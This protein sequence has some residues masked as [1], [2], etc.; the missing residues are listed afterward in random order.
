MEAFLGSTCGF[1]LTGAKVIG[2]GYGHSSNVL[3]EQGSGYYTVFIRRWVEW[4]SDWGFLSGV[5]ALIYSEFL[6]HFG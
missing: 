2:T 1:W 5:K 6:Q 4:R 3:W